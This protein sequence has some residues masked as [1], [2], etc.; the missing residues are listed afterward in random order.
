MLI[1]S[2]A[3]AVP[4]I[5]SVA[6]TV[7][8]NSDIT[9]S[10]SNFGTKSTAAP[11]IW[12]DFESGTNGNTIAGDWSTY[13]DNSG[14]VRYSNENQRNSNSSLN[15]KCFLD[16]FERD[17]FYQNG[18]DFSSGYV[19][20][21]IWGRFSR[22]NLTTGTGGQIK[23]WRVCK[24]FSGGSTGYPSA[25]SNWRPNYGYIDIRCN[26][27]TDRSIYGIGEPPTETW[28]H[29]TML[30]KI[31][32]SVGTRDGICHY[33]RNNVKTSRTDID[34][35]KTGTNGFGC[36]RFGEFAGDAASFSEEATQYY[37][38]I[39]IDDTWQRVYIGNAS[40]Y[41]ACS[42]LEIQ[43]PTAWSDSSITVTVNQGSHPN[44]STRYLY[45]FDANN[46]VNSSGY[47]ITFGAG[48]SAPIVS[49]V[50]SGITGGTLSSGEAV[51]I[52]GSGFEASQGTG[53]VEITNLSQDLTVSQ[54]VTSWADTSIGITVNRTGFSDG[55]QGLLFVTNDSGNQSASYSVQMAQ[56]GLGF[57]GTISL[58]SLD[59]L[60]LSG[61]GNIVLKFTEQEGD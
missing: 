28:S 25:T 53:K 57:N 24:S 36:V 2:V 10:G 34:W 47:E 4:S 49:A 26:D 33:Y 15:S 56:I 46:D 1:T 50:V 60:F 23:R 11:V 37:D 9:I 19:L 39:Y 12:E 42:V 14:Y 20:V 3:Y 59:N 35:D 16:E 27:Q 17:A 18:L 6:G 54:T 45:V 52:S 41:L 32:S 38:N 55:Q 13:T 29:E 43:E 30:I 51:T 58:N 7:S 21:D 22:G 40:T 31:N 44:D 48:S 5:S 8:H 61:N